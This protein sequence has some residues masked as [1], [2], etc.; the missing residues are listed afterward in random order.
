MQPPKTLKH[1]HAELKEKFK[2]R[3][4]V[5]GSGDLNARVVFVTEAPGPH[6]EKE[7][8]PIAGPAKKLF[9][10]L[11][12]HAGLTPR[13]IYITTAMKHSLGSHLEA[14]PKELRLHATFLKEE[15]KTI[16]PRIVVTMGTLALNGVGL[17]QPLANVR[18]KAL[19]MGSYSVFPTA[20]P[21][22]ALTDPTSRAQL[23]ADFMKLKEIIATHTA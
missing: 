3:T 14:H 4:L 16:A 17:R 11:L 22:A 5:L 8:A 7:G 23:E 21:S 12:K 1:I 13:K 18:G 2:D 9:N 19:N 10:Q 6:E 20:H 15:L